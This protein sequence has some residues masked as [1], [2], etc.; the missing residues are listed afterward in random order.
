MKETLIGDT[1]ENNEMSAQEKRNQTICPECHDPIPAGAY[2]C[3][4]CD[5]PVPPDDDPEKGITPN[6][7]FKRIAVI[8][9]LF[10]L[11]AIFKLDISLESITQT[12]F[13]GENGAATTDG[14]PEAGDTDFKVIHFVKVDRA[15]IRS[16]PNTKSAILLSV[17]QRQEVNVLERKEKWSKVEVDGT[18][19]WVANRL[20]ASEVR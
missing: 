16:Q 19:G 11:I 6:Q 14:V 4:Q 12:F 13:P 7:A 10:L 9:S 5:P 3:P 17:T 2:F 15:N 8:V 1:L 20:L 18:T